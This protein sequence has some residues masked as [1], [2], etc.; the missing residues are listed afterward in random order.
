MKKIVL[1]LSLPLLLAAC[2]KGKSNN[3]IKDI[4]RAAEDKDLQ[5][6]FQSDC[7]LKPFDALW[8]GLATNLGASVKS[9]RTEFKFEGANITRTTTFYT[10]ADCA[11][12]AYAL[13]ETGTFELETDKKK[14]TNDGGKQIDIKYEM[15]T[16]NA[17]SDAGREVANA[18]ALCGLKDWQTGK[19]RDVTPQSA[20][21]NCYWAKVPRQD[22]NVYRVDAGRLF[23]GNDS[24]A[25]RTPEQRPASLEKTAYKKK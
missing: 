20:Q 5:G 22:Y 23:L 15:L 19:D 17:L 24:K 7:N 21:A 14:K 25:E 8:S 10:S 13:R 3:P 12:D 4:A 18:T 6:S 1:L 16:A 2:G 11:G 9:S